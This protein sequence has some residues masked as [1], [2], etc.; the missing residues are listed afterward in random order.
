MRRYFLL[1]ILCLSTAALSCKKQDP[2]TVETRAEKPPV[3]QAPAPVKPVEIDACAL[4]TSEEIEAVQGEPLKETKPIKRTDRGL[5]MSECFFS[6]PTLTNSISL[7]V[8][9]PGEG[10]NARTP[11]EFWNETFGDEAK[12][13]AAKSGPPKK[14]E[15]VGDVAFWAGDDRMGALYVLAGDRMVLISVGG[16]GDQGAKI[17]KCKR[18]AEAVLNRL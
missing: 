12:A 5:A 11:I 8:G 6:L 17:E 2:P 15:G 1:L 3:D 9:Q 7:G 14:V 10:P 4:L 16:P 18:L 13:H